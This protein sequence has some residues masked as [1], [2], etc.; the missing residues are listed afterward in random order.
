MDSALA[1]LSSLATLLTDVSRRVAAIA[2]DYA[3][4][5]REAEAADLYEVE[6]AL[7]GAQRRLGRILETT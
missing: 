4:R 5:K 1:E 2:D 7:T 3:K 6:R